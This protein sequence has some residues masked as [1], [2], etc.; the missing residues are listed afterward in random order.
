MDGVNYHFVDRTQFV[1]MI[2]HGDFLE[3]AEVV[4]TRSDV[5]K[6]HPEYY[7]DMAERIARETPG[8]YFINQFGNPDNPA[9]HIATTGPEILEQLDGKVDAFRL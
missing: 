3:R 2:E 5:A 6:G 9:A 7:Q 1:K 8:A 4:L